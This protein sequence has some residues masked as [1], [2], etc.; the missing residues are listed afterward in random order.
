MFEVSVQQDFSAAHRLR[1]YPGECEKVHGHN[2]TVEVFVRS[3]L[4][5]DIGVTLDFRE[6]KESLKQVLAGLDHKDLN[7]VEPFDRENPSSENIAR[8]IYRKLTKTLNSPGIKVSKV[9][10][11]E[12][13]EACASYW[14][15]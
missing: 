14:E 13:A 15:E 8:Y 10:V 2:W 7:Q 11:H 3:E 1:G 6:I 4:L 12:T 5:N 9:S